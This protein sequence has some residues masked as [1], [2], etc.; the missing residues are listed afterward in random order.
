MFRVRADFREDLEVGA[1]VERVRALFADP[2]SFA[3]LMP[4]VES[5]EQSGASSAVWTVRAA[6]A[7]IGAVRG[8]FNLERRDASAARVEWG[9]SATEE[10]NLLRYAIG[11]E[12]LDPRRTLVRCAL[13]VE[14][15]RAHAR[16]LHLAAAL[17][18][19]R[20]IS[21]GVEERVTEMMKTFLARARAE[22]EG[23]TSTGP[24]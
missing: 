7:L 21:A 13:R 1:G 12:E 11:F 2:Q 15:R 17:I 22:L 18:G 24:R 16:D 3:R 20:R 19:E 6:I 14:L 23:V 10:K 9:P 4:C 5:V 8:H